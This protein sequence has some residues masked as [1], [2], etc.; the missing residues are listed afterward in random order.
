MNRRF[1]HWRMQPCEIVDSG[2]CTNCGK[3]MQRLKLP[4][5]EKLELASEIEQVIQQRSGFGSGGM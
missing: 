3:Q 4:T 2:E 5:A 1:P